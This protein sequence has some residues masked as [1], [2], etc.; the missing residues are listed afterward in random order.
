MPRTNWLKMLFS[1][2]FPKRKEQEV[3]PVIQ[4]RYKKDTNTF[5]AFNKIIEVTNVVRN[6]LGRGKDF[7]APN[8]VVY[9]ENL[10]GSKGVPYYPRTFP[11][12]NW[13]IQNIVPHKEDEPYLF[14]FFIATSAHQVVETREL[15]DGKYGE[16]DG[17]IE[18]Y[19]YGI[20]HSSSRT[21]LGCIKVVNEADL[22]WLVDQIRKS[23]IDNQVVR[24]EVT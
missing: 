11:A 23:W 8:E 17:L 24:M 14:P 13:I 18:D 22:R 16:V 15:I 2:I 19:G 10:N 21:T 5:T 20:H 6:E 7:R 1:L 12:G 4:I 3:L 9:T